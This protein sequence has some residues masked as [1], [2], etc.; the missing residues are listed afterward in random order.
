MTANNERSDLESL[1]ESIDKELL[2]KL[3]DSLLEEQDIDTDAMKG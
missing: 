3:L 2:L 1:V